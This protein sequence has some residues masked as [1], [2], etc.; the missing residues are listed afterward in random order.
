MKT[1]VVSRN[2]RNSIIATSNKEATVIRMLP[3]DSF[4]TLV[5]RPDLL[6]D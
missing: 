1:I 5:L 2:A 6:C 3:N 4:A